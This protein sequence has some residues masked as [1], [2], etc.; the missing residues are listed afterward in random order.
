MSKVNM[1]INYHNKIDMRY[2]K[3]MHF[4]VQQVV[5]NVNASSLLSVFRSSLNVNIQNI[6]SNNDMVASSLIVHM[7]RKDNG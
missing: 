4:I 2:N 1:P 7:S 3:Y 6:S 5:G